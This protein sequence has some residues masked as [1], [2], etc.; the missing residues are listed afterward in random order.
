MT[1][2]TFLVSSLLLKRQRDQYE[3]LA[4]RDQLTGL[5]NKHY[6]QEIAS[7]KLSEAIR[8]QRPLRLL[9]LDIDLFKNINDAYGHPFGDEGLQ[10]Y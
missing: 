6:L 8:H 1:T 7:Q 2:V 9:V 3:L 5:H 4:M 10:P